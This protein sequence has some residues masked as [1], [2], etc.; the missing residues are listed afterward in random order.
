MVPRRA[1]GAERIVDFAQHHRVERRQGAAQPGRGHGQRLPGNERVPVDLADALGRPRRAQ[2][3]EI[4]ARM[5]EFGQ[6][7]VAHRRL[8]AH[9]PAEFGLGQRLL[10]GADAVGPFRMPRRGQ[11]LGEIGL[12]DEKRGQVGPFGSADIVLTRPGPVVKPR[13]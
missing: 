8:A 11:V 12:A 10:D 6:H 2:Q 1:D 5:H 4:A 13:P 3:V 7:Q 9:Q